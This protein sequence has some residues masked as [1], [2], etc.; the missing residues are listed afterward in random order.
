M[1]AA[2]NY[3]YEYEYVVDYD[4]EDDSEDLPE[5]NPIDMITRN[6]IEEY[7]E[8]REKFDNIETN[9]QSFRNFLN[10]LSP[11]KIVK[12]SHFMLNYGGLK[13]LY[14]SISKRINIL[15]ELGATPTNWLIQK[16][17]RNIALDNENIDRVRQKLRR[18]TP[19]NDPTKIAQNQ[20]ATFDNFIANLVRFTNRM[21][22]NSKILKEVSSS[23]SLSFGRR[24]KSKRK[25]KKSIRKTKSKRKGKKS[26]RKTRK[27]VRKTRKSV[28]KSE[29]IN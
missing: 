14:P 11:R 18:L 29:K 27:S 5:V 3:D 17:E 16:L 13:Y 1:A 19:D 22:Q 25:G 8:F 10:Q 24:R 21:E 2:Y 23:S 4:D 28:K 6:E 20:K 9:E 7:V 26:V 12:F 15:L